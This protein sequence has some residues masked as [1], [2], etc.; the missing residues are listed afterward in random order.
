VRRH[1]AALQ[2]V[3]SRESLATDRAFVIGISGI[4]GIPQSRLVR[5]D[6][7]TIW[8]IGGDME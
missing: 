5:S 3:V 1:V 6:P 8:K 7:K 4:D 2:K